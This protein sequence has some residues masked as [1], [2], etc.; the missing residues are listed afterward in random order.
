MMRSKPTLYLY[1]A[2]LLVTGLYFY[3]NFRSQHVLFELF[4][5]LIQL[6]STWFQSVFP[7][8]LI[9]SLP[10][11][12]HIV[13]MCFFSAAIIGINKI[14]AKLIPL[15]W[16]SIGIALE[17]L[18]YGSSHFLQKGTFD[19]LDISAL[20]IGYAFSSFI[21]HKHQT[22]TNNTHL[23]RKLLLPLI[24][25]GIASSIGSADISEDCHDDFDK[26]KCVVPVTLT[27]EALRADI[28]PEYGNSAT[29]VRPGKIYS[30]G[31]LY[32]VDQYRGIHI[33]DQTDPQNP[34][35]IVFIPV[36]GALEISIEGS[37]LY[38]NSFTDLV[39]INLDH[40]FDATFNNESFNRTLD[41]FQLPGNFD[42]L[43]ENKN[44]D[45][46]K[47]K[48]F[49]SPYYYNNYTVT[50]YSEGPQQGF[51]IGYIDDSGK[52]VLFGEAK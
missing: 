13:F 16:L 22:S 10:S 31:Y 7:E 42:F 37:T 32:I 21:F 51:F 24:S 12:L 50:Y 20:L 41:L 36:I 27:W 46:I 44:V 15:A 14:S 45:G 3:I 23:S 5:N 33:F 2:L 17:V 9:N 18:Q 19:W 11:F 34:T 4:P 47:Y 30:K 28:Q 35:R 39:A 1:G 43:P 29:L 49:L 25:F 40:V 8:L 48:D 38:T 26:K 52:E 6:Q